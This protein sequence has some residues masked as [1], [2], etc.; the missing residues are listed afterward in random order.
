MTATGFWGKAWGESESEGEEAEAE[1]NPGEQA[2]DVA[3]SDVLDAFRVYRTR[4]AGGSTSSGSGSGTGSAGRQGQGQGQVRR[5]LILAGHSQGTA[6]A[7]RLLVEEVRNAT[8]CAI[9]ISNALFYQDRLGTNIRKTQKRVAFRIDCPRP[10]TLRP[11][12]RRLPPWHAPVRVRVAKRPG[13]ARRC[14]WLPSREG[15]N[16]HQPDA[17]WLRAELADV[18]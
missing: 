7:M 1:G 12:R 16:L 18:L 8:F 10:R 5:P 4:W 9:Y 14:P 15:P 2:L 3:Y 13:E 17:D 6:H 11:A